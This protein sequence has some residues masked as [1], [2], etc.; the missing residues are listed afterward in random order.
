M[1]QILV[2]FNA[3]LLITDIC[4]KRVKQNKLHQRGQVEISIGEL[5]V[6]LQ[7]RAKRQFLDLLPTEVLQHKH[8]KSNCNKLISHKFCEANHDVA[9]TWCSVVRIILPLL[10]AYLHINTKLIT[11]RGRSFLTSTAVPFPV[12][13]TMG[14]NSF[15]AQTILQPAVEFIPHCIQYT[16]CLCYIRQCL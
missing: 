2:E 1:G 4:L 8:C 16:N 14:Q 13:G 7:S 15:A 6:L 9:R 3:Y 11:K 5:N 12:S 10:C